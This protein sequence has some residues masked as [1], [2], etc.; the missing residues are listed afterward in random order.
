MSIDSMEGLPLDNADV[1]WMAPEVIKHQPYGL[2]VD[3]WSLGITI[4]EMME[5]NPPYWDMAPSDAMLEVMH[6]GTPILARPE[7]AS[8]QIK[9]F[10]SHCLCVDV[11]SRAPAEELSTVSSLFNTTAVFLSIHPACVPRSGMHSSRICAGHHRR[12]A[13]ST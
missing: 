13:T 10:L 6:N 2:K 9:S 12:Y 8:R 7:V 4:V 1:Y 11:R 5:G 3:I